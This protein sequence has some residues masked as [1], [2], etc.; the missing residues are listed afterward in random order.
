[1]RGSAAMAPAILTAQNGP[2][3]YVFLDMTRA[4]FDLSDRG[5]TGRTAPG[6]VDVL[7]WTERGIYRAGETVHLASLARDIEGKAIE[8]LPLTFI[9][10]RPDGRRGPA[11][12]RNG[13]ALGGYAV[14]LPMLE[15][16]MRGAWTVPRPYRPNQPS[17]REQTF[18]V[19]ISPDDRIEF[20]MTTADKAIEPGKPS[21]S[22]STAA[23]SMAPP[24]PAWS[25]KA[26]FR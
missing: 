19:E 12:G 23:I 21:P 18:L 17:I 20:D 5:V 1:M 13:G 4:G 6:A 26:R 9:V 3:D 25:S 24:A 16:A 15:T 14:D 11:S 8:K 2:A 7:T 22:I 10:T